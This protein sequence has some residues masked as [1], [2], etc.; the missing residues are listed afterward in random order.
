MRKAVENPQFGGHHI[1]PHEAAEIVKQIFHEHSVRDRFSQDTCLSLVKLLIVSLSRHREAAADLRS[2]DYLI[3]RSIRILQQSDNPNISVGEIAAKLGVS[4]V[5]MTRVFHKVLGQA[6]GQWLRSQ[7][8]EEAKKLLAHSNQ[9]IIDIA[10]QLG[11]ESSQYFATAFRKETG[12]SP[13]EYRT[14]RRE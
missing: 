10:L 4:Q 6:P 12:Q 2:E 3:Q 8:M 14:N 11:F 5:W 1:D 13:T 7:R 9:S